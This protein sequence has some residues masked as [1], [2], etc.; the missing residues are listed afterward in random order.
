MTD[1]MPENGQSNE[2]APVIDGYRVL[3]K[4]GSGATS[5]IWK[6]EQVSL[7][8]PVVI[9]ALS[10]QLSHEPEDVT[11]FKAEAHLAA[12]LKH[13]NIVQVYDFGQSKKNR[14]YYF[15]MEYISGY[16]VGDWIRRSGKIAEA[17]ALIIVQSV[18]MALKYAWNLSKIV[19]RDI[20]PD[21]IMV[22]GD[23]SIKVADLGVAH[24]V[25][26]IGLPSEKNATEV[27][28]GT[29]N[30]MAPEQI[31]GTDNID[32]RADIYALGASLFHIVTGQLPFGA[33][34][35]DMVLQ[36]RLQ[37]QLE[38]PQKVNPNL[39]TGV[40]RLIVKMTAN[41]PAARFQAWDEVLVEV[42]RLERQMRSQPVPATPSSAAAAGTDRTAAR[43]PP[44]KSKKTGA[45]PEVDR[46]CRHCGK[47]VQTQASYCA[48][49]GKPLTAAAAES[50]RD[51]RRLTIRLKPIKTARPPTSI[52]SA[53]ALPGP[54]RHERSSWG[55]W[56]RMVIALLLLAF[57]AYCAYQKVR[58]NRNVLIPVKAAILRIGHELLTRAHLSVAP[59]Q[60][61]TAAE[62]TAPATEETTAP[63][64]MTAPEEPTPTAAPP[65]EAPATPAEAAPEADSATTAT[66]A[67]E[68]TTTEAAA[69]ETPEAQ[70]PAEAAATKPAEPAEDAAAA[71]ESP[72]SKYERLLEKCKK[73]EPQVGNR[74]IIRF[75]D[76]RVPV[77]GVFEEKTAA[78]IMVK[79]AAGVIEYPFRLMTEE[80]RLLYFPEERAQR[81]QQLQLKKSE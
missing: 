33:G 3:A 48:F 30:Y 51:Q 47:P 53:A 74:I 58:Y 5:S 46:P 34:S 16:S 44:E 62:T 77:E 79:V 72:K 55:G 50:L 54:L 9:K 63:E 78:G 4:L 67:P 1:Q 42:V 23:G 80:S 81:L 7:N 11:L 35:A 24:A 10:E 17:D 49:C 65:V 57:L 19:H 75:K 66:P 36:R 71:K 38:Y 43:P 73:Q 21:N 13:P 45:M 31:R 37:E 32:C 22:D 70:T 76:G 69:T 29:P 20:K 60:A 25:K 52:P 56:L 61:P 2:A 39:S 6:A 40:T 41:E 8:R 14:C 64:Q 18:A 27:I 26:T 28:A 15:V 12:N 59:E 68:P